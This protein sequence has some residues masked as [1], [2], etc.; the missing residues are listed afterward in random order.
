MQFCIVVVHSIF[1]IIFIVITS[2]LIVCLYS[3]ETTECFPL[4]HFLIGD[5]CSVLWHNLPLSSCTFHSFL[6]EDTTT[7][8]GCPSEQD[9]SHH[10]LSTVHLTYGTLYGLIVE[11]Y[12]LT[13]SPFNYHRLSLLTSCF[14]SLLLDYSYFP[15]NVFRAICFPLGTALAISYFS[16]ILACSSFIAILLKLW[17]FLC[18]FS[19]IKE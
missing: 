10:L 6:L 8:A 11:P 14:F 15:I 1:H 13:V 2:F 7:F 4:P 19:F 17:S 16:H 5:I 3:S 9:G 18:D 12:L